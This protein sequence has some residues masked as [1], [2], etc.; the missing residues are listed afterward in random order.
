MIQ[1]RKQRDFLKEYKTDILV[2]VQQIPIILGAIPKAPKGKASQHLAKVTKQFVRKLAKRIVLKT[3]EHE[4][5]SADFG[6]EVSTTYFS[7]L[8]NLKGLKLMVQQ[9]RA[10]G[11]KFAS[12]FAHID[13]PEFAAALTTANSSENKCMVP[14]TSKYFDAWR[15]V[16]FD[17]IS[18]ISLAD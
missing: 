11:T 10:R 14:T 5:H 17:S 15:T 18:C 3:S 2:I 9:H 12:N 6:K 16:S 1:G 4:E 13:S 8:E 7:L